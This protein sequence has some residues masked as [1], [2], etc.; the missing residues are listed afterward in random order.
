MTEY[1]SDTDCTTAGKTWMSESAFAAALITEVALAL[2]T[3]YSES[4]FSAVTNPA[5]LT[6]SSS[7]SAPVGAAEITVIEF[8][9]E[10]SSTS[11]LT[12]RQVFDAFKSA[13]SDPLC[14]SSASSDCSGKVLYNSQLSQHL[15]PTV[16]NDM[17]KC[18]NTGW[19]ANSGAITCTTVTLSQCDTLVGDVDGSLARVGCPQ[20][21]ET[22]G[23]QTYE[24]RSLLQYQDRICTMLTDCGAIVEFNGGTY[25]AAPVYTTGGPTVR[26]HTRTAD[27]HCGCEAGY[28]DTS[29][30]VNGGLCQKWTPC[31]GTDWEKVAPDDVSDRDC[32]PM[33]VCGTNA[34]PFQARTATSDQV[35]RCDSGFYGVVAACA[36]V[37]MG[38]T[39]AANEVACE[40]AGAISASIASSCRYTAAGT[41]PQKCEAVDASDG[42]LYTAN[43]CLPWATACEFSAAALLPPPR[44]G[45]PSLTTLLSTCTGTEKQYE[46]VVPDHNTQRQCGKQN[47]CN[48]PGAV[49][50]NVLPS[51]ALLIVQISCL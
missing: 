49:F 28:F 19:T 15:V 41:D 11:A 32:D 35:C 43:I 51:R 17:S 48:S 14:A 31:A 4:R 24:S 26:S 20:A 3:D 16:C 30:T 47:P 21:C 50:V 5:A 34:S 2:G 8:S 25:T 23:A 7:Y 6:D 40:S 39:A 12:V 38:G 33:T 9:I 10:P 13:T 37:P 22:C 42:L 46:S 45:L 18:S 27:R 44:V 1:T 29:P 36:A